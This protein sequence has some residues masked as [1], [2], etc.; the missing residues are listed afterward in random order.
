MPIVDRL[1]RNHGWIAIPGI[2]RI[3]AGFQLLSYLLIALVNE[4]IFPLLLLDPRAILHGEVWRLVSWVILPPA[5]NPLIMVIVLFFMVFLGEM[6]ESAWGSFRLTL[7]VLGGI[8]GFLAGAFFA[9]FLVGEAGFWE[10]YARAGTTGYLWVTMILFAVAVMNPNLQISLYGVIPV[11]M[12]WVAIFRGGM[13]LIDLVQLVRVHP[14]LGFSLLLAMSNFLIV[15]GPAALRHMQQRGEVA[16]RRRKFES[17]RLPETESLHRCGTCGKTEHDD[18]DLEFRVAADGE[19][20][21]VDHLPGKP[22]K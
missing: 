16:V 9:Y 1:E 10:F 3:L 13:I 14:L 19:E 4:A 17:A 2:V 18:P 5:G 11:K 12:V 8:V 15:F 22:A 7:Y 21:C 6:L 20:Y